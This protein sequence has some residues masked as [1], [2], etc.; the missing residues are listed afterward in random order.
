MEEG[1]GMSKKAKLN[2]SEKAKALGRTSAFTSKR[3]VFKVV[4]QPSYITF[5]ANMVSFQFKTC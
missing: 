3:P 4:M 2:D 1:E 5:E